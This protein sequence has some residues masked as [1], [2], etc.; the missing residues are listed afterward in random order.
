M[1]HPSADI[2]CLARA[3]RL[4]EEAPALMP[5]TPSILV[6]LCTH[7]GAPYLDKLLDSLERQRRPADSI[8][9]YDWASEDR[10]RTLLSERVA[11]WPTSGQILLSFQDD[12]P[13]PRASFA[14]ALAELL[15][16]PG[17]DY[18]LLCDQDDMWV[19]GKIESIEAAIAAGGGNAQLLCSDVS[20]C[21]EAGRETAPS[22]YGPGSPFRVPQ[23]LA[24]EALLFANPVVGM[25]LA[26]SRTLLKAIAPDLQRN[27]MMHD[28]GILLLGAIRGIRPHFIDQPLVRYRQH[29]AN[30]L[31]ASSRGVR[32]RLYKARAHFHRLSAQLNL[33]RDCAAGLPTVP[34]GLAACLDPR[35]VS[36]PRL[37]LVSLRSGLWKRPESLAFAILTLLLW[38]T[39]TD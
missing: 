5:S 23:S 7:N 28:W 38:R 9:I 6:L 8:H 14:Q 2:S 21:D 29:G 39:D 15:S 1:L 34:A 19:P 24:P 18:V 17:W 33:V 22:F 11:R 13:G 35:G 20:I 27:W 16:V 31:G 32:N 10:T 30:L 12:A 4:S 3:Q 26:M 37:A 36:A 25:T